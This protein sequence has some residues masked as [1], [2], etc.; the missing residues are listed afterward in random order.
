MSAAT[1]AMIFLMIKSPI[2][3]CRAALRGQVF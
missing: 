1:A 3:I 2:I